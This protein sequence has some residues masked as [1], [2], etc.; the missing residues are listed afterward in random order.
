VTLTIK[1]DAST[2]DVTITRAEIRVPSVQST[3]IGDH[4]LYVR[5]YS[6]APRPFDDFA[7]LL[8]TNLA[9]SKSMVLDLRDNPGGFVDQGRPRVQRLRGE[10]GDIR[11]TW[12][13]RFGG[14][15]S[16]GRAPTAASIPLVVL[17]N[18][19]S[20][21]RGGDRR[22]VACRCTASKAGRRE[23]FG[24]GSGSRTSRPR[25]GR[26]ATAPDDQ[27]WYL[28]DGSTVDHV[29][30]RRTSR[31]PCETATTSSTCCSRPWGSKGHP[32]ERGVGAAAVV[33]L[34]A[35]SGG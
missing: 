23:D 3:M 30:R 7:S 34:D 9:S 5:I 6:S 26:R 22:R 14:R 24:K 20:A 13:Q 17:V 27:A 10:R 25:M 18:A 4:V 11:G 12:T 32:A 33:D 31:S 21:F 35:L 1:R 19:N 8:S 2:F 29:G 28:P 16:G 15:H